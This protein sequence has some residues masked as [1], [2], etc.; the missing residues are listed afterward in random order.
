M[1]VETFSTYASYLEWFHSSSQTT[2]PFTEDQ[3]YKSARFHIEQ[4]LE[5]SEEKITVCE[6]NNINLELQQVDFEILFLEAKLRVYQEQLDRGEDPSLVNLLKSQCLQ[7]IAEVK[8]R[9]ELKSFKD[10]QVGSLIDISFISK[11]NSDEI[12]QKWDDHIE[13]WLQDNEYRRRLAIDYE[14]RQQ[15]VPGYEKT[16][17][18][19]PK[20]INEGKKIEYNQELAITQTSQ[21]KKDGLIWGITIT[22]IGTVMFSVGGNN[23]FVKYSGLGIGGIAGLAVLCVS[24]DKVDDS[25]EADVERKKAQEEKSRLEVFEQAKRDEEMRI[26]SEIKMHERKINEEILKRINN[27]RMIPFQTLSSIEFMNSLSNADKLCLNLLFEDI[28]RKNQQ[29]EFNNDVANVAKAGLVVG[30]A[31]LGVNTFGN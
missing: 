20:P 8:A 19:E 10:E 1:R 25:K 14:F 24:A 3:F 29:A 2:T 26:M 11:N 4:N 13:N 28:Q 17:Y 27:F 16:P 15:V 23:N 12:E 30:L 31:L 9:R 7:D 21:S 6:T 18:I 5:L 22:I